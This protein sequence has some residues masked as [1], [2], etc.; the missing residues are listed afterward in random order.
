MATAQPQRRTVHR[1]GAA[2]AIDQLQYFGRP[3]YWIT[4]AHARGGCQHERKPTP[5]AAA[6]GQL[7]ARKV[8]Q[9]AIL[10]TMQYYQALELD[11][12]ALGQQMLH[13]VNEILRHQLVH[14]LLDK[15]RTKSWP[16]ELISTIITGAPMVSL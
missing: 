5:V 16:L 3:C 12:H 9:Q 6:D 4:E 1:A 2:E 7:V 14:I 10:A 11:Q 8:G 15:S 13:N